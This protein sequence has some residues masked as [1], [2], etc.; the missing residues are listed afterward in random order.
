MRVLDGFLVVV[1]EAAL[2]RRAEHDV[3]ALGA[4]LVDEYLQLILI[5]VPRA[6]ARLFLLLVIVAELR[7]EQVALL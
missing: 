5:V 2:R 7:Y 4:H 1:E 3:G 6:V